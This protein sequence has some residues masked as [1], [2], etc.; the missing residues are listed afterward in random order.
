MITVAATEFS[1]HFGLY[2]ETVQREVIAVTS[3]ER[4]TGYFVSATEYQDY[5]RLKAL[6]AKSYAVA[7]L[8]EA[9]IHE[10]A[11]TQMDVRHDHLND[12]LDE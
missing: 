3:H 11:R 5:M 8:P 10:I 2:R 1:K 12:L 6:A 4:V 9:T 7:E